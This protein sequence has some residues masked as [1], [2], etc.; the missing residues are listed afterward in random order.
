MWPLRRRAAPAAF[1][2][3]TC[4]WHVRLQLLVE[5]QRASDSGSL[6]WRRTREAVFQTWPKSPRMQRLRRCGTGIWV[7]RV[8]RAI[9]RRIPASGVE[10]VFGEGALMAQPLASSLAQQLL[11]IGGKELAP[12]LGDD[13]LSQAMRGE[14][15]DSAELESVSEQRSDS[16]GSGVGEYVARCC[17]GDCGAWLRAVLVACR[18]Q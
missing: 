1:R 11:D 16:V 2:R 15:S 3:R 8:G 17:E 12:I 4:S 5:L 9:R 18:K 7:A 6:G 10:Q 14:S 13:R